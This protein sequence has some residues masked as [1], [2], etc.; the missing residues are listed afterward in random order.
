[1]GKPKNEVIIT[2]GPRVLHDWTTATEEQIAYSGWP[3]GMDGETANFLQAKVQKA[4]KVQPMGLNALYYY[5]RDLE[6]APEK[7]RKAVVISWRYQAIEA[8]CRFV[9]ATEKWHL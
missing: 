6:D 7:W 3:E 5:V 1:M 8:A 9:D 2:V 4:L